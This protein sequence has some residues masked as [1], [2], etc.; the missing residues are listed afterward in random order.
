MME[1]RNEEFSRDS[2]TFETVEDTEKEG[3]SLS[4]LW[5]MVYKHW[6][7]AVVLMLVGLAGG[8]GYAKLIKAPKYQAS[9]QLMIVNT[10]SS[11]TEENI[12]EALKKTQI[13]Y[14]YMTTADVA[15]SAGQKLADKGY[16]VYAK[17]SDGKKTE[18]IDVAA[19]QKLY[20]VSIPT[21]TSNNTSVFLNVTS[22][23]KSADMAVDV[24][25]FVADAT[26]TLAN[27]SSNEISSYLNNSLSKIKPALYANDTSTSTAVIAIVGTLIGLVLGV[28]YGIVR[29]LLDNKVSSKNDLEV[30]SGYKVIG[31]IPEYRHQAKP[32]KK[33]SE[34]KEH[35]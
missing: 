33:E 22:T 16:D 10:S 4:R 21:V 18:D 13:A 32:E 8:V 17:D 30:L 11:S 9:V 3:I 2:Q 35:E 15:T 27:D 12:N 1:N 25:N 26:I 5:H 24:A 31:M 20:A 23:C 14:V 28:A 34:G 6:V 7:A 19:V 29:E